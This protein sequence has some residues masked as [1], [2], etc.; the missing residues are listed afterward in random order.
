MDAINAFVSV[1]LLTAIQIRSS[2]CAPIPTCTEQSQC[3]TTHI[4]EI[5]GAPVCMF[6]VCVVFDAGVAGCG[7]GN[8]ESIS[9]VCF[10]VGGDKNVC[11]DQDEEFC[12]DEC[13]ATGNQFANSL[14]TDTGLG[15]GLCGGT[16]SCLPAFPDVPFVFGVKDGSGG[17]GVGVNDTLDNALALPWTC[18]PG[19]NAG[20]I[21]DG[22][23][24]AECQWTLTIPE[25]MCAGDTDAPTAGTPAPTT[26]T[27][28]P[29]TDTPAPTTDTP[30]PTTDTPAPT[31]DTPA[32]T[33]TTFPPTQQPTA[34]PIADTPA[35]TITTFPPTHQPTAEPIAAELTTNCTSNITHFDWDYLFDES[36]LKP[37]I[38]HNLSI[39]EASLSLIIDLD[40]EYLGYAY[41]DDHTYGYG[42]TYVLDFEDY[43]AEQDNIREPGNCQNRIESSFTSASFADLWIY[44]DTPYALGHL[45]YDPY[46]AYPP[47]PEFWNV[48]IGTDQCTPIH[49][50]GEFSWFELLECTDY[51]NT[52]QYIQIVDS[53]DWVNL[54]GVF[55]VNIVSPLARTSETGYYRVYQSLSVPFVIAVR[56]QVNIIS[57]VGIDLFVITII[58]VYKEDE[59]SDWRMVV[60]T[61]S[62]DFLQLHSPNLIASPGI[63]GFS[64][65]VKNDSLNTGCLS[66][67]YL[68]LQLWEISVDNVTCPPT[69]FTGTYTLQYQIGCNPSATY[70]NALELCT[71]YTDEY[72]TG[73]TLSAP[74]EWTD[75]VCDPAVFIVDFEGEMTFHID[76]SFTTELSSS[77][78][79]GFGDIAYVQIVVGDADDFVLTNL[80]LDNVWICTT[81]PDDEP[82]EIVDASLGTSGCLSVDV[83]P[84]F[85]HHLVI[86]GVENDAT[87]TGNVTV[88]DNAPNNTVRISFPIDASIERVNIY[89]Q[90]Q[91]TLDLTPSARRRRMLL[92]EGGDAQVSQ[93]RHYSGAIGITDTPL[94]ENDVDDGIINAVEKDTERS[95]SSAVVVTISSIATAAVC[96]C[97]FFAVGIS[98][99]GKQNKLKNR[100]QANA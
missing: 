50:H 18:A 73:V 30:A 35:P 6:E 96:L 39:N 61:E 53:T 15:N 20:N 90:A 37:Y 38:L 13:D 21:C 47:P 10:G 19:A 28:A 43:D 52:L 75:E 17:C 51:T 76:S 70:T 59:E 64:F 24:T 33:I 48:T 41:A 60:L 98:Y 27:P 82:L 87:A 31:A 80:T 12:C 100:M 14:C 71:N 8:E 56:K 66:S 81:S 16:M 34:E 88:Y 4:T 11:N 89:V 83:D 94:Q 25:S 57:S 72:A 29:T 91:I 95:M 36:D 5:I 84:G 40:L 92:Q 1:I 49:Y 23:N 58:A 79:Y 7:K 45:G 97:C 42:V 68:C 65:G 69:D 2:R 44:S 62:A 86:S 78:Q 85:P 55:Y 3:L 46:L 99:K 74:L 63:I 67:G 93:S 77:D 9:H 22:S 32:P 54:T 26:D